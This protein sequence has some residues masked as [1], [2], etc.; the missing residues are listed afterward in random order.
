MKTLRLGIIGTGIAANQLYLPELERLRSK[1]EVVAVA[2]RRKAKARSFAKRAGVAVVCQS[3]E[4]LLAR[5]DIDAVLLS[6]PI[7]VIA[8]WVKKALAAGKH[9][10]SEKPIAASVAEGR[11]LI[12]AAEKFQRVWLVGENFFFAPHVRAA[13]GWVGAKRL[14]SVRLVEASKLVWMARGNKYFETAWRRRPRFVGGFVAD[15][16]VHVANV[17][18]ELFGM[19]STVE[20]ITASQRRELPPLDT[21]VAALAFPSGAVGVWRSCFSVRTSA[22]QPMVVAYGS[23]ANLEI[24]YRRSVLIPHLGQGQRAARAVTVASKRT[25]FFHEFEHFYDCVV[26]DKALAFRPAAALLDL[27]LMERLVKTT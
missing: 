27:E 14:G 8:T 24:Y 13:A 6:L 10:L 21:V 25:G 20:S 2:N 5:A 9:V 7:D 15:G 1:I 22:E 23:K 3:G 11:R 4:E 19:P 18:R 17:V 12:R 16:G 26:R